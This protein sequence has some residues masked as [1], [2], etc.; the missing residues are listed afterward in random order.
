MKNSVAEP[1][2]A[3]MRVSGVKF[4]SFDDYVKR[5]G[6]S[7]TVQILMLLDEVGILLEHGLVDV[8]LVDNLFGPSENTRLNRTFKH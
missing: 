6:L 8:G 2:D 1:M 5:C 7:D 3:I 4:E